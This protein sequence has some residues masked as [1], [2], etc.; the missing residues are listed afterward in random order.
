[1]SRNRDASEAEAQN[2]ISQQPPLERSDRELA[3][4]NWAGWVQ[5]M[6]SEWRARHAA[7]EELLVGE[8]LKAIDTCKESC[9][10]YGNQMACN[11]IENGVEVYSPVYTEACRQR[12]RCA[13]QNPPPSNSHQY[14]HKN[15][16]RGNPSLYGATGGQSRARGVPGVEAKSSI[17]R[18]SPPA[19][20]ELALA[21]ITGEQYFELKSKNK[22]W[23]QRSR[24]SRRNRSTIVAEHQRVVEGCQSFC[25]CFGPG[26]SMECNHPGRSKACRHKCQCVPQ[27][28]SNRGTLETEVENLPEETPDSIYAAQ[29]ANTEFAHST[30]GAASEY[31]YIDPELAWSANDFG[32]RE[33][34]Y[35]DEAYVAYERSDIQSYEPIPDAPHKVLK[36]IPTRHI[37][38]SETASSL[39]SRYGA[40]KLS[41]RYP[42]GHLINY[43]VQCQLWETH[44]SKNP[45]R[46][47]NLVNAKKRYGQ[48][49]LYPCLRHCTCGPAPGG[50]GG[51]ENH[52]H[53][54]SEKLISPVYNCADPLETA[55]ICIPAGNASPNPGTL[56]SVG[57]G[58][59][60]RGRPA[61]KAT[62]A[63]S[64][65]P[66]EPIPALYEMKRISDIIKCKTLE[67]YHAV[68]TNPP[69][70]PNKY[71]EIR[72]FCERRCWCIPSPTG[73]GF[74]GIECQVY[75]RSVSELNRNNVKCNRMCGCE[76]GAT[77]PDKFQGTQGDKPVFDGAQD[78]PDYAGSTSML[79]NAPSDSTSRGRALER[80]QPLREPNHGVEVRSNSPKVKDNIAPRSITVEMG[81][82]IPNND[83]LGLNSE[84][85]SNINT[86]HRE[87]LPHFTVQDQARTV[88]TVVQSAPN[89]PSRNN[90]EAMP[91]LKEA[92]RPSR[93]NFGKDLKPNTEQ[94]YNHWANF[95]QNHC[96]FYDEGSKT[97]VD[98]YDFNEKPDKGCSGTIPQICESLGFICRSMPL[99][100]PN[101]INS[102]LSDSVIVV[103]E[104][105]A[106]EIEMT[107]VISSEMDGIA[108]NADET[109]SKP[110]GT[111][112]NHDT[113]LGD[114]SQASSSLNK[115]VESRYKVITT[116]SAYSE[117]P[118]SAAID[119]TRSTAT[120]SL[121]QRSGD[122]AATSSA[123][124]SPTSSAIWATESQAWK[125]VTVTRSANSQA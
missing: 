93:P 13:P 111:E 15:R 44:L 105:E 68:S 81:E 61:S 26:H 115:P 74:I 73:Y 117:T 60:D 106:A 91:N 121:R 2:S 11:A 92:K 22:D 50:E 103:A 85:F 95:C 54:Q 67:Q 113:T 23:L 108:L 21:C 76:P 25:W 56:L 41:K 59:G 57:A 94:N 28:P 120:E 107:V 32:L 118:P 14:T 47:L 49:R 7:S 63:D 96:I 122:S 34:D 112:S 71:Q 52:L 20:T 79:P 1:M 12:C 58:A 83:E 30:P 29:D 17:A 77:D 35:E 18:R 88:E 102:I 104:T 69:L 27:S 16:R 109:A 101:T 100:S 86:D 45:S 31:P 19:Q 33:T 5:L 110:F 97:I 6:G 78:A 87:D 3:C 84:R 70:S 90:G 99:E 125:T 55:C 62:E 116:R 48:R 53:C 75:R 66:D 64:P 36:E 39:R 82:N 51:P 46:Y 72:S 8:F 65:S 89:Q 38:T 24:A 40:R 123:N 80:R 9:M 43:E 98:K 4:V 37:S 42:I 114:I 10:C 124:T 119:Q